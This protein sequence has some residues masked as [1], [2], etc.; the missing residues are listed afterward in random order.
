MAQVTAGD[1]P[2]GRIQ[3]WK[4]D[5]NGALSSNWKKT[6]DP[7]SQWAGFSSFETPPAGVHSLAVAPLRDGRLQVFIVDRNH[8]VWSA[9]KQTTASNSAWTGLSPFQTPQAGADSIAVAQLSDRR[10]QVFITDNQE[11]VWSAWKQT[12]DPNSAW[13]QLSPFLDFPIDLLDVWGEG[14]INERG[15]ITGFVQAYNL[16]KSTQKISNG[17]DRGKDIPNLVPVYD[18]DNPVF[19]IKDGVVKYITLMGAPITEGTAREMYRVLNKKNGVVMLYDPD[20]QQR[21]NFEK[22]MGK[23]VYKPHD[24]LNKP[25]NEIS[26]HPV[27]IYGFPQVRDHDEL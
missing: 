26:I 12:L 20:E 13:T 4:S 17:P 5:H 2:D 21:K 22:H 14:R 11:Q 15:F 6:T 8:Q 1:L 3:M 19:P 18:Y 27:Y 25:F 7:N 16:N 10:L 23:L 9:W 24:P